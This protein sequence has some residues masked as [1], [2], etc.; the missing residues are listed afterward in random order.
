VYPAAYAEQHLKQRLRVR[1]SGT[2]QG[3]GFRPYV[4]REAQRCGL[5]GWVQNDLEGVTVEIEGDRA[6]LSSFLD[7]LRHCSLRL[8]RVS[9]L[10]VQELPPSGQSGFIIL[11]SGGFGSRTAHVSPDMA[12]CHQCQSDIT[13]AENRRFAYPFTN[14]T[15]C[16]PRF[17]IVTGVPYDRVKTTMAGFV[18]CPLCTAEYHD[19]LNRRFHAQPNACPLCGPRVTLTGKDG[20]EVT[21]DWRGNFLDAVANGKIVAVK[22][23]GGFHLSCDAQ[24]RAA[25]ATLRARKGRPDRPFAVM[26]RDLEVIRRFC[27]LEPAEEEL[28]VSPAAPIVLLRRQADCPL[29]QELAPGL[30]TLGVML[31]YTPLHHLLFDERRELLVMTS[32]NESGLPLVKD[33]GQALRELAA[34]ADLFLLHDRE[35]HRRCDDSLAQVVGGKPQLLR[36]SRG[37]VPDPLSVPTPPE[38]PVILGAGGDLKNTFCLLNNGQAYFGP[39]IGDL[40]YRETISVYREA[41]ETMQKLLEK[42]PAVIACDRHPGYHSVRLAAALPSQEVFPVFH[43]HAHLASCMGE[44]MLHGPVI[45][46]VCDGSG[47]GPD[48]TVWG[49]EVLLGDYLQFRR[50]FHLEQVPLPGGEAA[51]R[52]PWRMAAAYLCRHLGEEGKRLAQEILPQSPEQLEAVFAMMESGFNSPLT[53][54]CGRL[55]D[56]A[57]SLLGVAYENSY[58]GQAATELAELAHGHGG[59]AYPFVL[60]RSRILTGELWRGMVRDRKHGVPRGR[61]AANFQ[62]TLAEAFAAAVVAVRDKEGLEQVVLSGGSFQNGFLSIALSRRL[63]EQGFTVYRHRQVPANDGGLALGQALVAAWRRHKQCV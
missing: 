29:P 59:Q 28:L 54:S 2:V 13:E 27:A 57:A 8:A 6:A 9:G 12:V 3:V 26:C 40:G 4:Y 1:V 24:N 47:Y 60:N 50:Q 61:V 58:E 18:M 33:N 38:S 11:A 30:G 56:A 23:L 17:T 43:H 45:A 25:V 21:G 63:E 39:H 32:G 35:I 5:S 22:G 31:P 44:H 42:V 62:Q 14:C 15:D 46:V 36:R 19:P 48:G 52:Q 55:Y 41:L 37:Y 34:L 53:S 16:G 10:A 20:G 49:G 7:S 51:V